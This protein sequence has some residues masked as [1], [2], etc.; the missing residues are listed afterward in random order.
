VLSSYLPGALARYGE[1]EEEDMEGLQERIIGALTFRTQ[2]YEDVEGDTTFTQTAWIIVA[3]TSFLNQLGS[4]ANIIGAIIGTLFAVAGFYAFAWLVGWIGREVFKAT[5]TTEE[6]VR[7]LG[8][9]S[10]W[11]A[12]GIFGLLLGGLGAMIAF[13]AGL[14]GLVAS[15]VAAKAA[16]DLEWTQTIITVVIGWLALVVA[17]AIAGTVIGL[18]GFAAGTA[19]G[20]IG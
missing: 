11:T 15:F 1:E 8:L 7:T 9:A 20:I 16:L 17:L 4:R 6:L 12:L 2:V 5:V 10:I 19:A 18:L 3:V 13:I 14:L